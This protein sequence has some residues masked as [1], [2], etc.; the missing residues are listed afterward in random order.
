MNEQTNNVK[1]EARVTLKSFTKGILTII[2]IML[3]AFFSIA[4]VYVINKDDMDKV[5]EKNST[6]SATVDSTGKIVY[7]YT[8]PQDETITKNVTPEEMA[9]DFKTELGDYIDGDDKEYTEAITYLIQAE[10]VT[11]QPYIDSTPEGEL[12]GQIKFY[13]YTETEGEINADDINEDNRLKYMP[14]AEFNAKLEA[15][16]SN[17]QA[18]RDIFEHFTIDEKGTVLVACGSEEYRNIDTGVDGTA[19]DRDLTADIINEESTANGSY[20][21]NCDTGFLATE[22]T[23]FTKPVD[24]LSLVEQYVMPSNLLYSL[25]IQTRDIDFVTAIADLAYGNEI[26]IGIYDNKSYSETNEIY[27]YKKLMK[28]NVETSFDYKDTLVSITDSQ[29]EIILKEGDL[30]NSPYEY[31]ITECETRT[32]D[33]GKIE[34]QTTYKKEGEQGWTSVQGN[35]MYI[36]GTNANNEITSLGDGEIYKTTYKRT[37]DSMS[38]PTIGVLL[39][40]TWIA[41]WEASYIKEE[42]DTPPSSTPETGLESKEITS[43]TN[44]NILSAFSEKVRKNISGKLAGHADGLRTDVINKIIQSTQESIYVVQTEEDTVD[45]SKTSE[46]K[47]AFIS[48]LNA[49]GTISYTQTLS[50]NK[51]YVNIK[52]SS[53]SSSSSSKYEKSETIQRTKDGEKFS[54]IFNDNKFHETKSAILNR[55]EWFWEYIRENEDTAKLEDTLRYLLNIATNSTDFG[56]FTPEEIENL[57]SAFKPKEMITINQIYGNTIETKLWYALSKEGYSAY[58]IAGVLGNLIEES[59]LK[60]NNLENGFESILGYTDETYTEAVNNGTYSLEEF[61]SDHTSENC[62]AGYGLA[63]WTYCTRK[64]GLYNFAKSRGVSIDNE[65]MQI[66]YLIGELTHSGGAD[67][68]ANYVLGT[69]NG[70]TVDDWINAESPED[71]AV[72]FCW[73]FERPG[74]PRLS[75]RTESARKFYETYKD[76]EIGGVFVEDTSEDAR[77]IGTFTSSITRKT[78]TIFDQLQITGW[79]SSCNRA[80]QISVCSGYWTRSADELIEAARRAP[81]RVAPGYQDLYNE[82]GLTYSVQAAGLS[83]PYTFDSNRIKEQIQNGGYV[84]L[85]V[86]GADQGADGVSKYGR[87]WAN[88]A[89]WVSILGYREMNGNEEIFVS[90]SANGHTGW[91]PLDE[92]DGITNNV[93]FVN[94]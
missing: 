49:T 18:N 63:Q 88:A 82:C 33:D 86:R 10:T 78:F 3:F 57:F 13:R 67:G 64:E 92:F 30:A 19:K 36:N 58:A 1:K 91:V 65:D 11:K 38:T 15:Y 81:S 70:Y 61:I 53:S 66:E 14:L 21:G 59:G 16:K 34:H 74:S 4:A 41:K 48:Q 40:D 77:I 50:G 5:S 42:A 27:T 72:A 9:K 44:A 32:T 94:E 60:S 26:A 85:Y 31:I 47:E 37:V 76:F 83:S 12:N 20:L 22:F 69:Y 35:S 52:F 39:A 54:Q 80:A 62:G 51:Q 56:T 55:E 7:T 93:F 45:E 8:D 24:Y 2:L 79:R 71:A 17:A 23:I 73:I 6:Y 29:P 28:M 84:I 25:L 68:Y 43:Y 90:D 75:D 89:H 87:D 46:R